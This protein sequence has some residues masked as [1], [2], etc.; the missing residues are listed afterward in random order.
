MLRPLIRRHRRP[1]A[2]GLA[3]LAVLCTAAALAPAD[4]ETT[5][6]V[7]AA[8]DL[9]P[10]VALGPDDVR[11]AEWP[12]GLLPQGTHATESAVVDEVIVTAFSAGEPITTSRLLAGQLAP[13]RSAVPVRVANADVA[14]V[15][16]AGDTVD[17]VLAATQPARRI[18]AN[19]RVITVPRRDTSASAP[20]S[21]VVLDVADDDAPALAA[22]GDPVALII[23]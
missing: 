13:G 20:G 15:L 22:V 10:G 9:P 2:A 8:R 6:V 11:V 14:G 5:L 19:A 21:V 18:A 1:L 17:V 12:A 3:A 23:R 4:P 16:R 7:V